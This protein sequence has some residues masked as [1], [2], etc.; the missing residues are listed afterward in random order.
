MSDSWEWSREDPDPLGTNLASLTREEGGRWVDRATAR[1]STMPGFLTLTPQSSCPPRA[2]SCQSLTEEVSEPW[3]LVVVDDG[4][5]GGVESDQA[6][7]DPVKHLG[8]N[9]V[10]DGDTQKP[11]L[12]PEVGGPVHLGTFDAGSRKRCAYGGEVKRG[13][14]AARET[15]LYGK[16][17]VK[18]QGRHHQS[19]C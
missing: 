3:G 10:P 11:F 9:H 12:V 6:Q 7:H 13:N 1:P 4:H 8:F 19:H 15:T 18:K 5:T 2:S 14:E 17:T 16:G